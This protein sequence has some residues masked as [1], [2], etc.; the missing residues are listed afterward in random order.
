MQ[1]LLSRGGLWLVGCLKKLYYFAHGL[2]VG[3][4]TGIG[5]SLCCKSELFSELMVREVDR[6]ICTG[7]NFCSGAISD[8]CQL[9]FCGLKSVT[10]QLC[11]LLPL[12]IILEQ[13]EGG[14]Q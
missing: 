1:F 11:T 4:F 3:H 9:T 2:F 5:I 7:P 8:L 14:G 12:N 13:D 6:W 10:D